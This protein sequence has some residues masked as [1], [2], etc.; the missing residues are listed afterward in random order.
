MKVVSA[1]TSNVMEQR[2]AEVNKASIIN[3]D[4]NQGA[5]AR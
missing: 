2:K 1:R 4:S 5:A 3:D